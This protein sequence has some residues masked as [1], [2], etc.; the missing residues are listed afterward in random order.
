[1]ATVQNTSRNQ[2]LNIGQNTFTVPNSSGVTPSGN[3][4]KDK[5]INL[6]SSSQRGNVLMV[7]PRL[8]IENFQ[9]VQNM[10]SYHLNSLETSLDF[11]PPQ[12]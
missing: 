3:S 5:K 9:S 6:G 10:S 2:K 8:N 7:D 11:R 4:Q 12:A 1:M